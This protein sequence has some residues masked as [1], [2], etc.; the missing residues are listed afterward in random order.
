MSNAIDSLLLPPTKVPILTSPD[1]CVVGGGA[2]GISAA[3]A[4]SRLGLSTVLVERYG[5]CGG[6]TVAGLSG[7]ICGLYSSGSNPQPV[8]FGFAGEFTEL[9]RE[10]GGVCQPV[11]FG[12]TNYCRT[13]ASCGKKLPTVSFGN[14]KFRSSII[15]SSSALS[16]KSR[17]GFTAF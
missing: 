4:A 14:T 2:A 1:L 16:K 7:T 15:A 5:F 13:T 6:A 3:V 8:V 10:R 17:E 12:R 11:S 9:L